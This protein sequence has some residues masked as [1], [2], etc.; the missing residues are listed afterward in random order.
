MTTWQ[1]KGGKLKRKGL[2]WKYPKSLGLFYSA[3]TQAAGWKPNEEEYIMMGAAPLGNITPG[4]Y[5][6]IRKL[7]DDGFNFHRGVKLNGLKQEK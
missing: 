5:R 1:A 4:G 6:K 2:H 7:W 3:M